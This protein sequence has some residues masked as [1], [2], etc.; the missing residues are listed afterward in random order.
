MAEK[1]EEK[2]KHFGLRILLLVTVLAGIYGIGVYT[3]LAQQMTKENIQEAM[4][5]AGWWGYLIYLVAFCLGNLLH[6]PGLVFV[7][8]SVVVF[9]CVPGA[10]MALIGSL[11]ASS[12]SFFIVRVIGGQALTAIEKPL[13]RK[14][15][16]RLDHR[17]ISTI[18]YLRV[19]F[20]AS[21]PLNYALALSEVRFRDYFIGSAMGLFIPIAIVSGLLAWGFGVG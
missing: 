16:S 14:M 1:R 20:I 8:A 6:I 15:L 3:G 2:Q 7:T 4:A 13:I 18:A 9:G 17:P 11:I 21:P 19:F 12:M 5:S 10:V